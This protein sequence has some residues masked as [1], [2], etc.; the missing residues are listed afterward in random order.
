MHKYT[1]CRRLRL[2]LLIALTSGVWSLEAV[3]IR[4]LVEKAIYDGIKYLTNIG[5]DGFDAVG[6]ASAGAVVIDASESHQKGWYGER[7]VYDQKT[8]IN[9]WQSDPSSTNL[10]EATTD[11]RYYPAN[12][13]FYDMTVYFRDPED[14]DQF[15]SSRTMVGEHWYEPD[16]YLQHHLSYVIW[17][18]TKKSHTKHRVFSHYSMRNGPDDRLRKPGQYP[19]EVR[20][21]VYQLSYTKEDGMVRTP[22]NKQRK[23]TKS[24]NAIS[25]DNSQV[26]LLGSQQWMMEGPDAFGWVKRSWNKQLEATV[27]SSMVQPVP[28]GVPTGGAPVTIREVYRVKEETGN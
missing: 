22:D 7:L 11:H 12:F 21:K 20:Y 8:S 15:V 1:T 24:L 9:G 13:E 17:A 18:T 6:T 25:D 28:L 3:T 16:F 14:P 10:G 4:G 19:V 23:S 2:M 27:H 26:P 5:E